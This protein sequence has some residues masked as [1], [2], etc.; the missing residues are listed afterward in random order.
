MQEIISDTG[1]KAHTI[2]F[3]AKAGDNRL[4]FYVG[5][6][7]TELWLDE[8]YLFKGNADVFRRDFQNGTVFVNATPQAQTITT[9]GNFRRIKGTQDPVNDGSAVGAQLNLP[10]YDAAVLLRPP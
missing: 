7:S 8:V 10:A 4:K 5:R 1:W 2:T 6:E 3:Q 9:N